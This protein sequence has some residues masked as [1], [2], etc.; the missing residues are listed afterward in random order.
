[1]GKQHFKNKI[2]DFGL[3]YRVDETIYERMNELISTDVLQDHV[4]LILVRCL[5]NGWALS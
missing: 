2:C 3:G 5:Q 4:S 1:M